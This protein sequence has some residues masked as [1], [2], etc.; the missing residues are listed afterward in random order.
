MT[1]MK[2]RR[3]AVK[4]CYLTVKT[5]LQRPVETE[6]GR[7]DQATLKMTIIDIDITDD[8]DATM[9]MRIPVLS[10]RQNLVLIDLVLLPH[11]RSEEI[12]KIMQRVT[13]IDPGSWKT[14]IPCQY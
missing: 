5:I 11:E 8:D 12:A 13:R 4:M 6:M 1:E 10:I 3:D 2:R 14:N 9:K 7:K